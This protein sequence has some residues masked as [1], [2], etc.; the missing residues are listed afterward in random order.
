MTNLFATVLTYSAPSANYRGENELNRQV[1]QKVTEGRFEYA[2]ISPE[3]MRNALRETLR[4]YH[5]PANRERLNDEDQ[6]AV[7][8][9]DFPRPERYVDDFIFGYFVA[10]RKDVPEAIRKARAADQEPFVFKRDSILRMN[11]AK[12]LEPYRYDAL[13]TQSPLTIKNPATPWQN[14]TSS[15]L[16]H[17]ETIVTAFQYPLALNLDDFDLSDDRSPV[18]GVS[19]PNGSAYGSRGEQHAD[20]LRHLLR[21]VAELNGVAG[22]HA[23][24]YF[25]MAPASIVVRI[26]NS[27]VAGHDLYAFR[28]DGSLPES[29]DGIL[30]GDYPGDEF[31]LGGRIVRDVL[32]ADTLQALRDH[33]VATHR[34]AATALDD[35]ARRVTGIGFLSRVPA[36]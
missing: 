27:L 5:L 24:S 1:V 21:A 7:R 4:A 34:V 28:P 31:L 26:T 2:V 18:D 9:S 29:V 19:A 25:E 36:S 12:A 8:F 22:N 10:D 3:A 30:N 35:A 23:R 6:L 13:L 15:A 20:W 16:L 17:R 33:G 32:P 14:S 11:L